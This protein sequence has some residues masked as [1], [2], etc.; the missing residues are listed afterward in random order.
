MAA[1]HNIR[2]NVRYF[3]KHKHLEELKEIEMFLTSSISKMNQCKSVDELLLEEARC[4]QRYYQGFNL[5]LN[6]D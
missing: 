4:R 1:I 2:A 3:E 5:F 6:D